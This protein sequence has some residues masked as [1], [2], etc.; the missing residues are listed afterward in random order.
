MMSVV[1]GLTYRRLDYWTRKGF[2]RPEHATP[3]SGIHRV[4]D[5]DELAVA[6]RM[7]RLT[8]AGID[9]NSAAEIA[10]GGPG[11]YDLGPGVAVILSEDPASEE[12]ATGT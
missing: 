3:G 7:L 6:N 10:R 2:L 11:T 9:L 5:D 12:S 4:W 1:E 8:N